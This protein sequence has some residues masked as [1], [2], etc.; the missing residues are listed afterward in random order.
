M[1]NSENKETHSILKSQL[2]SICSL[3]ALALAAPLRTRWG[4]LERSWRSPACHNYY[5]GRARLASSQFR[6][7]LCL[8][9]SLSLSL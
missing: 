1:Y 7:S 6:R 3:I 9:L 8:S 5:I 2:Q 4:S